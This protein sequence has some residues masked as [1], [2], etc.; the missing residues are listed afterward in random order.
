MVTPM[1]LDIARRYPAEQIRFAA[2][3]AAE[4]A[5][6][7]GEFLSA[8]GITPGEASRLTPGLLLDLGGARRLWA[9]EAA[10]LDAHLV[11]GLPSA[12][13]ALGHVIDIITAAA[14]DRAALA[15]AGALG[16][17]VFDLRMSRFAWAGPTELRADV[18]LGTPDD[19][20]LLEAVADL[21]LWA[22]RR[23][24]RPIR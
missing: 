22:V 5:E 8:A 7:V 19:E 10:G 20:D 24:T 16:R 2:D 13:N 21:L 3:G 1:S 6:W 9:W 17:A 4:E 12:R 11:A 23:P 15:R 14:A 18:A